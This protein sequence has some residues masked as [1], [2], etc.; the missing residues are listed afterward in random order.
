MITCPFAPSPPIVLGE[1]LLFLSPAPPPPPPKAAVLLKPLFVAEP[2][3]APAPAPV[4]T[5]V[6]ALLVDQVAAPERPF[7]KVPAEVAPGPP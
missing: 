5:G 4:G 6:G 7:P 1:P 3:A 2:P